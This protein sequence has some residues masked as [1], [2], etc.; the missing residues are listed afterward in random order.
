[1]IG[2]SAWIILG[3]LADKLMAPPKELIDSM[4]RLIHPPGGDRT[5]AISLL[6]LAITPAICE[7]ALFRGAILRGLR[8]RFDP[9]ASCLLTGLLF[10]VL[11]GD[12]WRLVPT[13]LLGMLLSWV[14]LATGSIIPAMVIH[15]CNNA[16]LVTI[17]YFGWDVAAEKLPAS[18]EALTLGAAIAAFVGGVVVIARNQ[19]TASP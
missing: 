6:A 3:V 19:R 11:H 18:A 5:L 14:A 16:A 1:L 2:L 8:A 13:T 15:A 10:G 7:E 9:F 12:V 4:R 17:G